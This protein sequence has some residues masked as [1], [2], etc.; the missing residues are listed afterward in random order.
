MVSSSKAYLSQFSMFDTFQCPTTIVPFFGDQPF[1]GD[2]VH[3]KGLGPPPIPVGQF[4]LDKLIDA[5]NYMKNPDVCSLYTKIKIKIDI[6]C[7]LMFSNF[8]TKE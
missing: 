7:L 2:R 3:A 1:W 4:S 5:I 8:F 6:L